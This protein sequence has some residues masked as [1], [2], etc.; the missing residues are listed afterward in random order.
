ML[1]MKILSISYNPILVARHIVVAVSRSLPR[2]QANMPHALVRQLQSPTPRGFSREIEML[3]ILPYASIITSAAP[4]VAP[5]HQKSQL[6]R[7]LAQEAACKAPRAA[8]R[9]T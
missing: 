6:T 3:Q 2:N 1:P 8:R 7:K 9:R 4:R 5:G